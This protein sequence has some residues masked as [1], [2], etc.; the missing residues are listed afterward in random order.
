M[1]QSL[2]SVD[3]VIIGGGVIGLA[4]AR[5]L[6]RKKVGSI[7]LLERGKL[8]GEASFAAAGM[9]APQAEADAADEFFQFCCRSRDLYPELAE[10]LLEETGIDIELDQTGT[11]YC[12]F[13]EEDQKELERRYECHR[14]SGLSVELL[15]AGEVRSLE[16]NLAPNV[17]SALRF[18]RD[19]Q[20]ENRRLLQALSAANTIHGVK[21]ITDTI[22]ESIAIQ[23]K[24]VTGIATSNGFISSRNVIVASGAWS[25]LIQT[26]EAQ[27]QVA[28]EPVRG[29]MI[30]FTPPQQLTRHVVFSPRGYIVPRRDGR[31]LAGSTS[32]AVGFD[33]SVTAAGI[34]SIRAHAEEISQKLEAL[35]LSDSWAGLRPRAADGLP[36][37]GQTAEVAGLF[38]ATGH[39]RNG[40]LLA[41]LTGELI[42]TLIA[43]KVVVP[44]LRAFTP[45]RF[46][47]VG[48]GKFG[49]H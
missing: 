9:L 47:P 34:F 25:S 41:P 13:T 21:L 3:V 8:G 5:N 4:I 32:E 46:S 19:I 28:I 30:C 17:L 16:P 38:Y 26:S 6:A 31:L 39:Y 23:Q 45:D 40:I 35:P 27:P 43:D 12:A 48:V 15:G 29:Q 18:A 24:Q 44:E 42:A 2:A 14:S 10:E 1:S 36:V 7:T 20:V 22:V 33:K 49:F 11:L 37:L